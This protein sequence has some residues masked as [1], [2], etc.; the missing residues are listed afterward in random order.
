MTVFFV[1]FFHYYLN[2]TKKNK[3]K[4]E[5]IPCFWAFL[6]IFFYQW[7]THVCCHNNKWFVLSSR[8]A[9][10]FT[11]FV[12]LVRKSSNNS[13]PSPPEIINMWLELLVVVFSAFLELLSVDVVVVVISPSLLP[14]TVSFITT[15]VRNRT[16]PVCPCGIPVRNK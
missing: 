10:S 14:L 7:M 15:D 12:P 6:N 2:N 4:L 16:W 11:E 1:F 9:T 13:K 5:H 3:I 8:P